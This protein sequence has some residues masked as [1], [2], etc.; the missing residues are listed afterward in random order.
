MNRGF[1]EYCLAY[2]K[3]LGVKIFVNKKVIQVLVVEGSGKNMKKYE[4]S[5][6]I[7]FYK[8]INFK[9]ETCAIA[10]KERF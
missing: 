7:S 2:A 3:K 5:G 4:K 10:Q 6:K 8:N 9:I 1:K